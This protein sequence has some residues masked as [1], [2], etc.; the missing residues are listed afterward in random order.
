MVGVYWLDDLST[1][2]RLYFVDGGTHKL[3]VVD[4]E[5]GN[6]HLILQDS[7]SHFFSLDVFGKYIYYT[8]WNHK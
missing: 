6:R 1:E 5:G 3:E 8:D 2:N 4:L 7:D